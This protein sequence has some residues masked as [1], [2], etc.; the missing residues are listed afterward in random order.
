M[1]TLLTKFARSTFHEIN[2][3][4]VECKKAQPKEVMMPNNVTRGRG[5]ELVWPLG[6]LT[7]AGFPAYGYGRGG[8]PGYPGFGYPFAVSLAEALGTPDVFYSVIRLP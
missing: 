4:M 1:K 6:A 2:N 7:D 3:K 5:A 8:Y